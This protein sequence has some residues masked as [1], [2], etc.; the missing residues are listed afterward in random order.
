MG[1]MTRKMR[2]T[3]AVFA[4]TLPAAAMTPAEVKQ[5]VREAAANEVRA[6]SSFDHLYRYVLEKQ[7]RS[8]TAVREMYETSTGTI[9]RTLTWNG[10]E[11]TEAERALEDK[12]LN[13]L[14][15]D[16]SE[17]RKKLKD[18][19]EDRQQVLRI[20]KALPD[21]LVYAYEAT[22]PWQGRTAIRLRFHPNPGYDADS[23]ETLLLREAEGTMLVD[24]AERRIVRFEAVNTRDVKLG[25]GL[26]AHID[27]GSRLYV[28][29]SLVPGGQWRITELNV[30]ATG[31]AFFYLRSV[32][33]MQK[34]RGREFRPV[35][36]VNLA[37]A[38]KRLRDGRGTASTTAAA[39]P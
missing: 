38:L 14:V 36:D 7:T 29:Q 28:E 30:E 21:A 6:Y 39:D 8:G 11:L 5:L 24:A 25:L 3:I 33:V 34:Q 19:D 26:L 12:R 18:Q 37:E 9:A 13:A 31:R 10:R 20:V 17:R 32:R 2:S 15:Y 27:K 16:E 23:K 22:E 35:P 4:L 1:T